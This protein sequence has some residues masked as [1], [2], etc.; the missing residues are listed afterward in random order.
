MDVT[1]HSERAV[2]KETERLNKII[3]ENTTRH[4]DAAA[5]AKDA[6]TRLSASESK[7]QN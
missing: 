4:A 2:V 1:R 5:K 3:E 6:S 7:S